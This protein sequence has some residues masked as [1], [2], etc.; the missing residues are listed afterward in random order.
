[1]RMMIRTWM[2]CLQGVII[3]LNNIIIIITYHELGL[4]QF[5]LLALSDLVVWMRMMVGTCRARSTDPSMAPFI[6]T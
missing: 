2:A 1:M 6:L 4:G 5:G 3:I